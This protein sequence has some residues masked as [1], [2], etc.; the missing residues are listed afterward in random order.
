MVLEVE[1]IL[2]DNKVTVLA[3]SPKRGGLPLRNAI[4]Y[5]FTPYGFPVRN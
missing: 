4:I 5:S 2:K 1:E 3:M